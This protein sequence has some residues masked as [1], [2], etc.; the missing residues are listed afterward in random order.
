MPGRPPLQGPFYLLP[1]PPAL[2]GGQVPHF[3]VSPGLTLPG[4]SGSTRG[5]L[6]SS[7]LLVAGDSTQRPIHQHPRPKT[8]G[9]LFLLP[10]F[11]HQP[12]STD[13]PH[14]L[15]D[16]GTAWNPAMCSARDSDSQ[17]TN[18]PQNPQC[19]RHHEGNSPGNPPSKS[20]TITPRQNLTSASLT[21]RTL[22]LVEKNSH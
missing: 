10:W 3:Q 2:S 5:D 20:D 16:P 4:S 15:L 1:A 7:F 19:G 22:M 14:S 13:C 6:L 12:L 17:D 21:Q 18:R 9:S 8:R 11:T